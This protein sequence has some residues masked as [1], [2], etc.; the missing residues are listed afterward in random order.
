[1]R[2][3]RHRRPSSMMAA[4]FLRVS[5]TTVSSTPRDNDAW[6]ILPTRSTT[7]FRGNTTTSCLTTSYTRDLQS[8]GNPRT[9]T[10]FPNM[11]G[12]PHGSLRGGEGQG[13]LFRLEPLSFHVFRQFCQGTISSFA[14]HVD[15]GGRRRNKKIGKV[16]DLFF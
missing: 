16:Y 11:R 12:S 8:V 1:M 3:R 10:S 13:G 6:M 5:C 14:R 15:E 7:P 9:T 2:E 4:L